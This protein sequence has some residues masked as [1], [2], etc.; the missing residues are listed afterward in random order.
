M[1]NSFTTDITRVIYNTVIEH[2]NT[3]ISCV[4]QY[5]SLCDLL[6]VIAAFPGNDMFLDRQVHCYLEGLLHLYAKP[7]LLHRINFDERIPG[8]PSFYDL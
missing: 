6:M 8:L 3:W 1:R 5:C 2:E 4:L 7:T